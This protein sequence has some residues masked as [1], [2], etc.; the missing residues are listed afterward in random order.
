MAL[1]GI[2]KSELYYVNEQHPEGY[3]WYELQSNVTITAEYL[4]LRRFAG[5]EDEPRDRKIVNHLLKH[6]R[7]DGTWA[8]HFGGKGDL[9]T[10]VEAYFALKLAGLS[11][12]EP[13][14]QRARE[15]ILCNGGIGTCRVFTKIFLAL[16]GQFDW[17]GIPSVPP[18]MMLLPP[19][20]PLNIYNLSA[21]SRATAVP[22][23][24]V[25]DV[26]PVKLLPEELGVG[27]LYCEPR[28]RR[29]RLTNKPVPTFS[30]KQFFV[31]LDR[32][33]KIVEKIRLRP[34]RKLGLESAC[35]WILGHQEESGDWLGI[36]P[37]MINTVF[38]L[39]SLGYDVSYGPIRKGFEALER[40]TIETDKELA[41]QS[42]ISPVWDTALTG[43]AL[44]HSGIE[45]EHPVM[46][47]AVQWLA[48]KQ[49]R[50]QGDWSVKKP[51][52]EPGG[53]AFEFENRWHPDV[54]DSA[55]VLMFLNK[56]KETGLVTAEVLER[57]L[58]WILGM[59]CKDGGWAAFD[60][61]N[62]KDI[63]NQIPFGD[64]EAM[65][66]PSTADVTG[67]VLE[68]LGPLGYGVAE[69]PVQQALTFLKKT[70]EE[71]GLWWGRWGVNYGYG[72]WSVLVGLR[73]I[74]EDMGLP[75]VQRAVASL[76]SHQNPDG[77]WGEC[78]ESYGDPHLRLHGASTPSQTA[79]VIMALLAA[80]EGASEE[81]ARGISFLLE[82]QKTDGTWDEDEFT[83]TG[84][85]KYF[86]INYH[87]YR[88]CFPLMALGRFVS[89]F[90]EGE[91]GQ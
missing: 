68:L 36:Q 79:W 74:G 40:F 55:V 32:L 10:T 52:L 30:R 38:A 78:C 91:V 59:Q 18:E 20:V 53:W 75:Y 24:I 33:L 2:R 86:M 85:P 82:R 37:A 62:N 35:A 11:P 88:N 48:S 90:T 77:G 66:D 42:C 6:Q 57:G 71:D 9:S 61:D 89:Q 70:Q 69:K 46:R 4:M 44:W 15:F 45:R 60:V 26:K 80:Q 19:W 34:L 81:V 76:K 1:K 84:F 25:L 65:I 28:S 87:N 83:G 13:V 21:W 64:L 23:S 72:T 49:I 14:L 12:D 51:R 58:R 39:F 22:L 31:I 5:M 56:Y 43:L 73:S 3:W 7:D 54:D 41:L 8:I 29:P 50:E 27:E 17:A 16:F 63:A 47:K 67:R